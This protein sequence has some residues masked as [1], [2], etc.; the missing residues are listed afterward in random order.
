MLLILLK[1]VSVGM[2]K[3]IGSTDTAGMEG[4]TYLSPPDQ[5]LSVG[6]SV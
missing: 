3:Y 1:S 2:W 6:I 5:V 4:D